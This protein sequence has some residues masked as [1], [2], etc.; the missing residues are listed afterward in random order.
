[1]TGVSNYSSIVQWTGIR[2]CV[3]RVLK[4]RRMHKC[5]PADVSA[6]D[7][8]IFGQ[9]PSF[10]HGIVVAPNAENFLHAAEYVIHQ[11]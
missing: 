11:I 9:P 6:G 3:M 7:I 1:M 4:K 8:T 5:D 10:R 2:Q